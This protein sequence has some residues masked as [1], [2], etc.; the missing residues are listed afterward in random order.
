[1]WRIFSTPRSVHGRRSR[2]STVVCDGVGAMTDSHWT[3]PKGIHAKNGRYYRVHR[4]KWVG[5][6]RVDEGLR[7]L[8]A[9]LLEVP[10]DAEPRTIGELLPRYLA[11]AE[12]AE[13]TRQEYRRI[14][15][16]R[17]LHHFG[18]MPIA[19]L[20]QVHVAK[21]L[22]KRK[23]DGASTMGNRERAVLSSAYEF[24]LRRGWATFNPCRGV[25]RNTESHRTRYVTDVEFREA[26]DAAPEPLQDVLALALLTGLRQGDLRALRREALSEA[27]ISVKEGKTG[28]LRV[29]AWSDALRFFVR[30]ALERQEA[31]AARPAD[32][33][34]H[35]RAHVVSQY[36]LTNRF[37]APWTMAG[38]QTAFKR[39]ATDWHFHDIRAK[40]ASDAGHNI[41]GHGS[42]MLGVYVRHQKV[43]ALR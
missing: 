12:I 14:C 30:R 42:Q 25:R 1:M 37:G 17:L 33:R 7:A 19:T 39:L 18:R 10:I 13:R 31:L 26:F 8:R 32:P 15:E 24:G 40:A 38:L 6:T 4:H 3:I 35:R 34:R 43:S 29:V 28:K 41:L 22:E 27:G 20:T 36:V 11:E 23:R 21:Y 9:A 2:R 5:L 16:A